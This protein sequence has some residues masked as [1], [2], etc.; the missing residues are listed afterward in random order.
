MAMASAERLDGDVL[1]ARLRQDLK[2]RVAGLRARGVV[3]AMATVLVGDNPASLSYVGRKHAD[4]AE[5]GIAAR[6]IRLPATT[7]RQELL[8]GIARLNADPAIQGFL[9]QLPLPA[10]LDEAEA[11][12]AVD[13]GKDMDGLHPVNLGRLLA[14]RPG[15]L[16]CTPAGVLALLNHHDVPLAG[17]HVVVIG[18][19]ALVGRPLA[20]L[21]SM[22]GVD[23]T[24]TLAHS[25]TPDLAGLTRQADVIVSA[26]GRTDLV[27]AAMVRPG[28]AVVGVGI[29]YL[30]GQ[31]VSDIADDVA[32]VAR[33][34][35][36]RHGSVGS[37]TR[38]M[39]LKNLL[40]IAEGVAG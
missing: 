23:A 4:C 18:R 13:P 5:I 15:L 33:W 28:A 22:P 10:G 38:A 35:T 29:T 7:D 37:L 30:D 14:G 6:D 12:E 32:G 1:A 31:M 3:P 2:A 8:A 20:M 39:L 21:L 36:P 40:D 9:V 24:V 25:R 26:A 17:R 27:T 34:V 19:G 16:P 11:L